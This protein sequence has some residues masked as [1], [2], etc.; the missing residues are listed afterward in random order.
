M[1]FGTF[2][3][4]TNVVPPGG[5]SSK[6][7]NAKTP[8]AT[9]Q[10][11]PRSGLKKNVSSPNAIVGDLGESHCQCRTTARQ[12]RHSA[13]TRVFA[14]GQRLSSMPVWHFPIVQITGTSVPSG[15][16]LSRRR[17]ARRQQRIRTLRHSAKRILKIVG[18]SSSQREP[19]SPRH[20]SKS[21]FMNVTS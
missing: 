20:G 9:L 2:K 6:K 7:R 11:S 12:I 4:A 3:I 5:T 14:A 13:S 10:K 16:Q 1:S 17:L 19:S 18:S 21:I 15:K 8:L